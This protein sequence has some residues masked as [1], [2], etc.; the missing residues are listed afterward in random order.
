MTVR[1]ILI[2]KTTSMGDVIHALPAVADIARAMPEV[3]IDWVVEKSFADI[4]QLSAHVT[5]VHQVAVRQWRKNL[6][7][8]Q[9][10]RDIGS[11]KNAMA[12]ERYDLVIDLQGLVKSAVVGRWAQSTL[13]GY[14]ANSIKEPLASRF[15]QKTYAVSRDELALTRCRALCAKALGYDYTSLPLSFGMKVQKNAATQKPYAA[16]LVNTSRE[17]KLWAEDRWVALAQAMFVRGLEVVL[18]W[19]TEE[20]KARVERISDATGGACRVLPRMPIGKCGRV[21]QG[22]TLAVGVDTGLTHLAAATGIPTVGL[23]LDFP[24]ELV[25]LSGERVKSI[26]GV[27]ANPE[28]DAVLAALAEVYP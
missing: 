20:E 19:A 9:T 24:I 3:Q 17:T 18:L 6:F 13:A 15:Y 22:A 14:D 2:V 8:S 27:G 25:G 21:L 4:P 16:F 28:V 23:F 12:C 7:S 5:K 10:W 26:G 1:K 11:V